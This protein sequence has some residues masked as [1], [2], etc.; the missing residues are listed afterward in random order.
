MSFQNLKRNKDL[1]SKLVNEAEKVGGGGDNKNKYGDDRV[2]KPTV[3][4][5]R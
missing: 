3:D 2:W 1:I 4:K 5:A